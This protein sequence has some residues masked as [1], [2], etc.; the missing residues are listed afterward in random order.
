MQLFASPH[1]AIFSRFQFP[2]LSFDSIP[3]AVLSVLGRGIQPLRSFFLGS[4]SPA[5][6]PWAEGE[7]ILQHV[8]RGCRSTS[9]GCVTFL[10]AGFPLVKV[11]TVVMFHMLESK[12]QNQNSHWILDFPQMF[13]WD[14]WLLSYLTGLV[15]GLRLLKPMVYMIRTSGELISLCLSKSHFSLA[16]SCIN[17]GRLLKPEECFPSPKLLIVSPP[18]LGS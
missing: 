7:P 12:T 3:Q 16:R 10:S 8:C 15:S 4:Y 6:G 2:K 14:I 9:F 1:G 11:K 5:G 18:K 13:G 17:T